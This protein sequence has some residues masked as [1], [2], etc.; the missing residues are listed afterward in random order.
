MFGYYSRSILF[1][2]PENVKI[3]FPSKLSF[4]SAKYQPYS[5]VRGQQ[6]YRLPKETSFQK[7]MNA[8]W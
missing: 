4:K 7:T 1:T 8:K 5:I 2:N 6:K 3:D